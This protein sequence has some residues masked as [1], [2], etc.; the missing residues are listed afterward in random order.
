MKFANTVADPSA[1]TP[2]T[3]AGKWRIPGSSSDKP[4]GSRRAS[5]FNRVKKLSRSISS[6]DK[7]PGVATTGDS[8]VG[9]SMVGAKGD[10][11]DDVEGAATNEPAVVDSTNGTAEKS[12]TVDKADAA[13]EGGLYSEPSEDPTERPNGDLTEHEDETETVSA[14]ETDEGTRPRRSEETGDET[15]N[16]SYVEARDHLESGLTTPMETSTRKSLDESIS[17]SKFQEAL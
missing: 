7:V 16:E 15:G 8:T 6:K 1:V 13:S 4:R 10:G 9:P 3:F 2:G 12:E 14:Y 11:A 17:G 5:F